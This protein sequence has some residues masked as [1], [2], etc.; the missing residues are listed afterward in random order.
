MITITHMYAYVQFCHNQL[1]MQEY[2]WVGWKMIRS[3]ESVSG[4]HSFLMCCRFASAARK[5]LSMWSSTA[6][7]LLET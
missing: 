2:K 3:D 7:P 1:H 6:L 5:I 4:C